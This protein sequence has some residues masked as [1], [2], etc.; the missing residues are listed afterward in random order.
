MKTKVHFLFIMALV[1]WPF[2]LDAQGANETSVDK[3]YGTKSIVDGKSTEF[4][5]NRELHFDGENWKALMTQ[6]VIFLM[7]LGIAAYGLIRLQKG[8][9]LGNWGRL[10]NTNKLS[11]LEIR[12]LGNRQHLMVAAYEGK[13]FLLGVGTNGIH[14]LCHLNEKVQNAGAKS[15]FEMNASKRN[16]RDQKRI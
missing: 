13:K 2:F 9:R 5:G 11:I 6:V 16:F 12:S 8:G 14:F 10:S 3:V 15:D 7:V 4:V 1:S